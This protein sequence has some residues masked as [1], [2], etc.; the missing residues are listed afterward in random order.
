MYRMIQIKQKRKGLSAL[1]LGRKYTGTKLRLSETHNSVWTWASYETSSELIFL[2]CKVGPSIRLFNNKAGEKRYV[3][4]YT[5]YHGKG[6]D[7]GIDN[8]QNA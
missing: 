4:K 7:K 2:F 3:Y 1:K 6:Y 8:I 5:A